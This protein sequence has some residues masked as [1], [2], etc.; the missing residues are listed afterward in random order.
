MPPDHRDYHV[1]EVAIYCRDRPNLLSGAETVK[2]GDIIAI[3]NPL[4]YIGKSEAAKLLWLLVEGLDFSDMVDFNNVF[5]EGIFPDEI[6]YEKRQYC[7]PL[8]RLKEAAP[9]ID[10]NRVRDRNDKYQPFLSVDPDWPFYRLG[11]EGHSIHGLM[12]LPTGLVARPPLDVHGLVFNK[13]TMRFI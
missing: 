9:F 5:T 10:L 12:H 11:T 6:R 4:G 7:I 3:R 8:K 13:K 2:E 1:M